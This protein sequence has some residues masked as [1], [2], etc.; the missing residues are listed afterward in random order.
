M[1]GKIYKILLLILVLI[2]GFALTTHAEVVNDKIVDSK[3]ISGDQQVEYFEKNYHE[4]DGYLVP[5]EVTSLNDL[6]KEMLDLAKARSNERAVINGSAYRV[7]YDPNTYYVVD[8]AML[9]LG[10]MSMHGTGQA[11]Y[12]IEPSQPGNGKG[13]QNASSIWNSLSFQQKQ[14]VAR[15]INYGDFLRMSTGNSNYYYATQLC[16]YNALGHTN[17]NSGNMNINQWNE[18]NGL[19]ASIMDGANK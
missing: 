19:K 16:V 7:E 18:I 13:T 9:H 2:P 12:C 4:I 11:V 1:K 10:F 3:L 15:I 5:K 17:T 14:K 6:N 8:G